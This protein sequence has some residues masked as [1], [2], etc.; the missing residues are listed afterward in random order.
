MK[1]TQRKEKDSG[2]FEMLPQAI[3]ALK[4]N[5]LDPFSGDASNGKTTDERLPLRAEIFTEEQ[6]EEAATSLAAKHTLILRDQSEQLLKRL[7]SNEAIL[8]EVH[9][10]L[11]DTVK[12]NARVVP[13]AEWLLDNF[14]LIEEQIYIGKKHLPK[15]Y[16]KGL[17]QLQK[18]PSAGLPRIYDIA[19]EII[20][21]SDGHVNIRSLSRFVT[22]YQK[23]QYLQ[24]GE[25]WA[26]P[27][28]L[29]LALLENLRRLSIQISFDI[30]NKTLADYWADEMIETI[31]NDPKNL[32]LVIADMARS[33]VPL[34]SSF[35]AEFTRRLQEK[36]S[37]LTLA[38]D[39]LEQRLTEEGMS[40]AI[41]IQME[42]QKQAADQLSIS[43]SI[44][45]LRFL[46]TTDWRSFVEDNS[47][48]E[49]T[50]RRDKAGVYA[51]MDFNTRD[52]YRHKVERISKKSN[53][54]EEEVAEMAV[55][56]ADGAG[57]SEDGTPVQHVG[58]YLTG[59][60]VERLEKE[61]KMRKGFIT[62]VRCFFRKIPLLT[63]TASI[64]II[65][66]LIT[67][68]LTT[69]GYADGLYGW[70][71]AG[72]GFLSAIAASMLA[73]NI[74][75]WITA[76]MVKPC[77]LPRMDYS[78]GIPAESR[79]MVVI[80]TIISNGQAISQLI[81]NL[82]VH[83]LANKDPNLSFALLTDLKDAKEEVLE[84]DA[85][86][87]QLISEKIIALNKK[88]DR[89][90]NDIF[91]L[92]H[93]PRKW[94]ASNRR[95]MGY[96]RKRGKLSHLN[97]LILHQQKENF[98]LIIGDA[99]VYSNV[100]YIITLDS[101]TELPRETAWKMAATM[102][103]PLNHPVY[104]PAKKRVTEGYTILQPRVSNSLPVSNSSI[105]AKIHGNE[106]GTDPY[107]RATSDLY[108][109]VFGEGSFVGKGIYDVKAFE[110]VLNNR[111]PENRILSHDLLE[112]SY[113][114]AGLVTDVQ[115]YEDYPGSYITDMMRRQRW[116]RG[117]WQIATWVTPVVPGYHKKFQ[118]NN[119]SALSKW[120][121]FDNLRRS[122]VPVSLFLLLIAGWTFLNDPATWTFIVMC[123]VFLP[124]NINF[125][126]ELTRKPSDVV[127]VQHLIYANRSLK[128]GLKQL[129][130]G[131]MCLPYEAFVFIRAI[132]ITLWRVYVSRKNLLQWNP[133][134]ATR[135]TGINVIGNFKTMWVSPFTAVALLGL[136]AWYYPVSIVAA[137][138]FLICW[139][140][141][142]VITWYIS[143]PGAEKNIA[144]DEAK[145]IYLRTLARKIW[146][147][148][149]TFAGKNDNWL[150]P[151]NY[152]EHPVERVAHRTSPTN[153]GMSMLAN[154]TAWD[155]GYIN[156]DVLLDRTSNTV[157]TLLSMERYRGHLYNWYDTISLQPLAPRYVS[158]VDSGNF[159][160]H[161]IT[162]QQG[163]LTLPDKKIIGPN[164]FEGLTD[165]L[166]VLLENTTDKQIILKFRNDLS[167]RWPALIDDIYG[168]IKY[169]DA[170]AASY[171]E[172]L[173]ELDPD[174]ETP[175]DWWAEKIAEHIRNIR[176]QLILFFPWISLPAP[177]EKFSHLITELPSV[178]TVNQLS[179][180]EQSMLHKIVAC[181]YPD[182]TPEQN[183]WLNAL[184]SAITQSGRL[185]KEMQLRTQ[186]LVRQCHSFTEVEYDFLYDEKQHLLTIGYNA[187]EHRADNS[188]YD[189]LASEAR[190]TTFVAIAQGKIPQQ[191]W[192][193]L[194]RQ[195]ANHGTDPI[196]LSWSGSM[197][198]YLMPLLVM[199][200]FENTLLDQ[201]NRSVVKKQIEYCRSR[202]V[203]W[204]ISESGYSNVDAQ[205]NY[206]YRAFGVPGL[207][208]RRGLGSDLVIAPYATIMALMVEPGEAYSNLQVMKEAGFEGRYGF[209]EA[210]DY[211]PSRLPRRKAN[212]IVQSFMAHHQGMSFLSIAYLLQNQPMQERFK[213]DV[214]IKSTLLLLQERI[215]RVTSYYSPT[216]HESDISVVPGGN[217]SMRVITTPHTAIPE[218]QLLS[219]GKYHVML[220]NSGGGYSRWKN[221][222]LTR[223]REDATCDNWGTFIYIRDLESNAF[224]SAAYQPV[225]SEGTGYE[226]V[227]SQGRAEFRRKD[228][229]LETHTEVIVSPEDDVELRRIH[230]N[231]RS[232][233]KRYIEITSYAEVVLTSPAADEAHPAFSNLFVQ[234]EINEYR[235]AI[236]CTRRPRSSDETNPYMFHL[237][238]APGAEIQQV[239]YETDRDKFI[240][241]GNNINY[242]SMLNSKNGLSGESGS[243]LDPVISIQYRIYIE[244]YKTAIIDV[245]T[246]AA[247]NKDAC[248]VL[249]GKYQDKHIANRSLELAWT[250]SQVILRQIN[251]TEADAQLYN[252]I[253]GSVIFANG[254][255]R[256]DPATIIKNHRGQSALWSY[257]ISGDLPIVLLQIEDSSSL[258]LV[259]QMVQ[260]HAYWRLKGLIVD[261]VIWN[262]DHGGYR[263]EF[264]DRIHALVVPGASANLKDQPGGIFIRSADQIS[265]E[266]RILFQT[267]AHINISDKL[268]TLEE[269]I[270]RGNKAK[271]TIP[272]FSP[273]KFHTSVD[274]I[275]INDLS[276]PSNLLFYNGHGGFSSDGKEYIIKT[277]PGQPT[278]APWVNV[279]G[280]P[281]FGTVVSENAQSYTWVDN[282]HGIRLTPWNNDPITDLKGEA[283]Y[284]RDEESGRFW[285]PAAL[286]A[287]G[288]SPYITRHGFGYS[289]FE[290]SED[291]IHSV[292]KVFVD[293]DSPVK[294][295]MLTIRN[296]S[297]RARRISAT[298]YV[299]W[300]LSDLRSKGQMHTITEIDKRT[301][302]ILARN[303]YSTEFQGRVAFFD[304]DD[305]SRSFSADRAEFI[306]RNGT[307]TNPEAMNR[308]RLSGKTGA[309]L[310]P[311]AALQVAFDLKDE[312]EKVITFRLGA[313]KNIDEAISI[314]ERFEGNSAAEKALKDVMQFWTD[315]L[316]KVQ[317]ETPDIATNIL[318]NGWLNYQTLA[319]RIW[320]R[321]GFYQ[322][323]GAFGFRDQLQDTLS[324]MHSK[325]G[326]VREQILLCASRQFV[327]GDVQHW[328]H[329]PKGRGVRT[330]CS[331]DYL[332]LPYVAARYVIL[333]GDGS[334]LD[335]Q[336]SFLEGR[337][338]NEGEESY[339]DLPIRSDQQANLYDHCK[340]AI[341]H[342]LRF[343]THGLP[344][345]GSGDWNDGMDKVGQHGKGE[346]VWLAFFLYD[347]LLHFA[348][349]SG[350]RSD[351]AFAE[352][353]R[354]QAA[355]LKEHI[356]KNAWDGE[357]YRRAYFDDGS[358]LG[359]KENEECK[360]D[361]IAQSWSVLSG[362]G[363]PG[364][365]E[366]ALQSADK[367]L[368]RKEDGMIQLFDPPFDKSDMKP[369][370]IKGYV[371]GVR[372]NGGQYTHAAIW[373]V[374][375]FAESGNAER[376]WQLLQ[377][378][379]PVNKSNT[380]E[381]I[382]VYKVEPYVI[383]ADVY[384]EPRHKGRGGW[385]WYTGSAGW[386]YQLILQS[387]IGLKRTGNKL[388][389]S[390]I[391]PSGWNAVKLHY[392]HEDTTYHITIQPKTDAVKDEA[393]YTVVLSNEGGSK[394]VTVYSR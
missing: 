231:N 131:V 223:W 303:D 29:R 283:F 74:V 341:E 156:H 246:G 347:I 350:T 189:L 200:T 94:N 93:R 179:K 185:A 196:L 178:P 327:E 314:I 112:G 167:E 95:W 286:P 296:N 326:L 57:I 385:T 254:S 91:F 309:A 35:V 338:L 328:W 227:F 92:F 295:S 253:A 282:A 195:L 163:L 248:N 61:T 379:N 15:G 272:V 217:E 55:A 322:S 176:Q 25:L 235:H 77:L 342:G 139:F 194:G 330:T 276:L 128:D 28:M 238:K 261:L 332:W 117:D 333:T 252:R 154:L 392:R 85:G 102:A 312:E 144:I 19:V 236:L 86:L 318:A 142:P 294:F 256:T 208:F 243:V 12:K 233:K 373:L 43:N 300:V 84:E 275:L 259:K 73:M 90:N 310:D 69:I 72:L 251:A 124:V 335:E 345:I 110:E 302:A 183:D 4:K 71:L 113:T 169:A 226:A 31:E 365:T 119:V 249:V 70:S 138:P 218:V 289:I 108:Q 242:P 376:T 26:T 267:V 239:T 380:A 88:Y 134:N 89:N 370:Y 42:N 362:A 374:M 364:R 123:I 329:P 257:S 1:V 319:S 298:G 220:T 16:S 79:S 2:V 305:T 255:L 149:E 132:L 277:A 192:F 344:F 389:F 141:A 245:V 33:N 130:I 166:N 62:S 98:S 372:E 105:Y 125:L 66:G 219:N 197:F 356:N 116:V 164:A 377:M 11:T 274:S 228:N 3:S 268:G 320:A 237:M 349:I 51:L 284:I 315:I 146:S 78:K 215:P 21:H 158:T 285:S 107:T 291:G 359:S 325:P 101:D 114:R 340:K 247:D 177:E 279:L 100:R 321:S 81:E 36:G 13:A 126:W 230:I 18:G 87:V 323:G 288:N 181:Y 378:I 308:V 17:P 331:D 207:G 175:E 171:K 352:K 281:A 317:I 212:T 201:T 129:V 186:N 241:R 357:W 168:L 5:I 150:P 224:W 244:P 337:L 355:T 213:S 65:T 48:A 153:I 46:A 271:N 206:Q 263:Q 30:Q 22:G 313:A 8:L 106:P 293:K 118:K 343:G 45:S 368:V 229:A 311:C 60:G 270:N 20:S 265:N 145:I 159:I 38:L 104:D 299:E 209:Y 6:L 23:V 188:Y 50:L 266:D 304:V 32:V 165:A 393:Q 273:T 151:D 44:S 180:I 121:I 336:V 109:D 198:E 115:L 58:Y 49:Q 232:R 260:A 155:F 187:D 122:L 140:L 369:G 391:F 204:G 14:Y 199:P 161:V 39:W 371:P 290:H 211:T 75:N 136:L 269:Q 7:A 157:N 366:Q 27:I 363:E 353:C 361:S 41:L 292:M 137:S 152:Q 202:N 334:I 99:Q 173:I 47:I 191:S 278:P 10:L 348:G 258:D 354:M 9:E 103:H 301:A 127:F 76:L 53:Y 264:N 367:F 360:I 324:L 162:L 24:L 67:W 52:E 351:A 394:D 386:M 120:K 358:P 182:N 184:R 381:K 222:A 80:P 390:S 147:F 34:E 59:K 64:I 96:E 172:V 193:A 148:F 68:G 135:Q 382:G 56:Y 170:L 307:L 297:G 82:E 262:D 280:N 216:I 375:A 83:F 133:Y 250:H 97:E 63:Y 346:S 174:P 190:L 205:L 383:A 287:R 388:E 240:G 225:L 111:L 221:I 203:P 40:S 37:A 143:S 210:V 214:Q 387:F 384:A 234:T 306:G 316:N 160:G 54:S 339:Y